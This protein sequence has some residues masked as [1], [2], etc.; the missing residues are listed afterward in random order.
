[1]T[2]KKT[3]MSVQ[4]STAPQNN[5]KDSMKPTSGGHNLKNMV[6]QKLTIISKLINKV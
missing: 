6:S 4:K 1:M 3:E 5:K 2:V